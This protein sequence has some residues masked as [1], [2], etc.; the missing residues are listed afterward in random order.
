MT[1]DYMKNCRNCRF[2]NLQKDSC[3]KKVFEI[4]MENNIDTII[5][6]GLIEAAIREGFSEKIFNS[7]SKKKQ[8]EFAEEFEDAKNN[9]VEEIS[10]Q[11][12]LMLIR[13]FNDKC[14]VTVKD[15]K[16]FYCSQW[17]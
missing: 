13:R 5:E 11:V 6:D 10:E 7:I 3:T 2:F 8:G 4:N 16:E 12:S 1:D 15:S 17:D 14:T 9:W